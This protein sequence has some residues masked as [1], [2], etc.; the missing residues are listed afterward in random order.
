MR[1]F[2]SGYMKGYP[3]F[4]KEV[5]ENAEKEPVHQCYNERVDNRPTFMIGARQR[6]KTRLLIEQAAETNGVIVCP[7]CHMV[8]YI[9][10]MA[11]DLGYSINRPITYYDLFIHSKGRKDTDY[12]FD[13]YGMQLESIIWR[14]INDFERDH[15][16]TVMI[17][18]ESISRLNDILSGLKIC[19]MDGK[20]LR[21]KIELCKE[22]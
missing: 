7:S 20:K 15:V 6:G 9:I 8:E 14:A 1:L 22:D 11:R 10:Y 17:D 5:F 18:K 12:Y 4:N 21:L 13:E 3:N 2:N 19:D 16:K